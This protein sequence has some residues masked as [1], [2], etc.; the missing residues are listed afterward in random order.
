MPRVVRCGLIQA[1]NPAHDGSVEE[2]KEKMI[3][4]HERLIEEAGKK[5]VQ[6][7][8][9]QEFFH[10]PYFPAERDVKWF[11]TA[12]SVPGPITETMAPLAKKYRMVMILPVY[13][14][15]QEGVYFN[16]AAVIDAD[17]TYIGKMRKVHIPKTFPARWEEF[18]YTPGAYPFVP[19][20]T[21]YAKIGILICYDRHFH[22]CA[23]TLA[24][25]GAEILFNP[26]AEI[27][28]RPKY[29]WELDTPSLAVRNGVFIGA[30]NRV[31]LE[32]PWEFGR[33]FGSSY[34]ADPLGKILVRG[35]EA[36]DEVVTADLDMDLI[37]RIRDEEAERI[38]SRIHTVMTDTP[39]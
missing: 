37:T 39:A 5:G 27:E 18:Y 22:E 10:G 4:K 36:S 1:S 17:G 29:L 8:C 9:L 20:Q 6:I 16:C 30:A 19:F 3:R 26:S 25:Q 35:S 23:R 34:F 11:K 15:E 2:I 31:G 33:F 24:L 12:E 32:K 13:E 14:M 7:L 21:A 38:V 28:G